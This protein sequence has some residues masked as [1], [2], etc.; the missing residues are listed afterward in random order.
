MTNEVIKLKDVKKE[1]MPT[2]L[3]AETYFDFAAHPFEHQSLLKESISVYGAILGINKYATKWLAAT[4]AEKRSSA[5]AFKNETPKAAH[6]I[7]NFEVLLE[8]GAVFEPARIIG[9]ETDGVCHTIYVA[10]GARVIGSD[11]YLEKGSI[12]IGAETTIESGVGI[13]GAV[14]IGEKTE[15]RQGAIFAAIAYS[16]TAVQSVV[17]SKTA[18]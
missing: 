10:K 4:I 2:D 18:F 14:I 6:T 9:S 1:D 11:I 17:K 12:Y 8:D 7:G 15:V 16:A 5:K 3:R 13:K